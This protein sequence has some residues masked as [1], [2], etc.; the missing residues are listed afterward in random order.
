MRFISSCLGALAAIA[1]AASAA[2]AQT[3][4]GTIIGRV[5]DNQN[6]AVPG[7]TVTVE[8]PNLQGALSAIT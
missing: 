1:I 8:S 6:L 3:T 4:S 2:S 5:V 7:V